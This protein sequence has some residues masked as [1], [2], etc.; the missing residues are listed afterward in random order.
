M[1]NAG[2]STFF[3]FLIS[4]KICLGEIFSEIHTLTPQSTAA[5]INISPTALKVP[6]KEW[7]MHTW[8]AFWRFLSSVLSASADKISM[9]PISCLIWFLTVSV[10]IPKPIF[11]A[12]PVEDEKSLIASLVT[13]SK[14]SVVKSE[15]S[16]SHPSINFLL[17]VLSAS[18]VIKTSSYS[19]SQR[20]F[21]VL[22]SPY[23]LTNA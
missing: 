5:S 3:L 7:D 16:S 14:N 23:V 4:P 12:L 20:L 11:I 17:K 13:F 2:F 22:I 8:H 18:R 9:F 15:R 6:F 10:K 1:Q 21:F 19:Y